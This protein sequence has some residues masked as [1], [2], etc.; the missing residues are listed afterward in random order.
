MGP[1][2]HL[3]AMAAGNRKKQVAGFRGTTTAV[4]VTDVGG[5]RTRSA[6][7]LPP[8]PAAYNRK[9]VRARIYRFFFINAPKLPS[10][11]L[12][13][14]VP[15]FSR[16]VDSRSSRNNEIIR[17]GTTRDYGRTDGRGN[18][19]SILFFFFGSGRSRI[20][21]WRTDNRRFRSMI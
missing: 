16:R 10:R 5:K 21:V 12:W 14:S 15:M 17:R 6:P 13:T 1:A 18:A 20:T 9:T 8:P 2:A 3:R 4:T 11:R 19:V 7:Q